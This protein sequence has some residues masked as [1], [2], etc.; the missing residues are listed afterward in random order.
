M[1]LD[2]DGRAPVEGAR[3]RLKRAVLECGEDGRLFASPYDLALLLG[4]NPET[5]AGGAAPRE[6][7]EDA[8][9]AAYAAWRAAVLE[10]ERMCIEVDIYTPKDVYAAYL[11]ARERET[12]AALALRRAVA[13]LGLGV[14]A[15]REA[16][17]RGEG[18][19]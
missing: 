15:A 2:L 9:Y 14:V 17:G 11:E 1:T 12:R 5:V 7:G 3:F 10:H 8:A 19:P 18:T 13:P 4:M 6:G 16:R